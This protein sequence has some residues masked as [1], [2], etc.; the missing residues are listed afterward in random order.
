MVLNI[1]DKEFMRMRSA[2]LDNDR[3]VALKMI[4]E[5]LKRLEQGNHSGLKSHLD[6]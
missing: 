6:G 3:D 1:T 2:V 4:R 5:F